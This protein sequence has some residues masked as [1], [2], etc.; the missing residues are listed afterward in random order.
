MRV[1]KAQPL[2]MVCV[3]L[4]V[5]A[6]TRM[7]GQARA[8]GKAI[9]DRPGGTR[10]AR[11]TKP[12][13][14]PLPEAQWTDVHKQLVAKYSP[15]GRA[16]N[17]IKTLLNVP[18]LVD[19]MMPFENY[20]TRDSSLSPRHREILILRTGWLL[21]NEYVWSEHAAIAR[22]AGLT[23]AE[24]RRIAQGP[25]A[26]GWDPF[27]ATLLRAADQLF[28]N[29]SVNDATWKALA[30]SY[31]LYHL[32]DTVMT[33]TDFT[34]V[35]LMYN[36]LG[37]QPDE[38]VTER[39]PA[40]IPYRVVVPERE[41]PLKVARV[42]PLEGRG[43]AI[44][45]TFAHYPK[46]A[47][48]RGPGSNYVNQHSNLLPRHRELLILRT[49]WDCQAEYEWAQHVGN[50]GHGRAIGLPIER[51]AAG[52]DAPGWD[53]FE[54]W[55]LRAADE[56]YRDSFVSDRTWAALAARFDNVM[57]INA[58]ITA[59]NYRMVSMALNALGVQIDP[60]EPERF[61]TR[62]TKSQRIR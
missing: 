43:I 18:Q 33:V 3:A 21:G 31:D 20:I 28:R 13:I 52:P 32:M 47:T 36:S 5:A 41:P 10:P 6:P 29:S 62:D 59:S 12:R 54:A 23:A 55:L 19:G 24:L 37:V 50:V 61:P 7:A 1:M 53:P 45:R 56:L 17:G 2:L 25:D 39:M 16:G 14:A 34:T 48:P 30:A 44:G 42:E 26:N 22:K 40:D 51:L 38:G 35:S 57:M 11:L 58:L 15:D 4:V 9:P 46:L 49:G 60:E 27:E 8:G